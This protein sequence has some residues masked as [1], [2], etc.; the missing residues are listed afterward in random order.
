MALL[1]NEV[2]YMSPALLSGSRDNFRSTFGGYWELVSTSDDS[3]EY[4]FS[5]MDVSDTGGTDYYWSSIEESPVKVEALFKSFIMDTSQQSTASRDLFVP[6]VKVPIRIIGNAS[7]I[8]SDAHWDVI[9]RGGQYGTSSYPG[10]VK[11]A[12]FINSTFVLERPYDLRYVKQNDYEN[13][14]SYNFYS[15]TYDY[16]YYLKEYQEFY[17]KKD[18]VRKIPNF[19]D[20]LS[21]HLG[22][23]ED[24]NSVVE[25]YLSIDGTQTIEDHIF[26]PVLT[27]YLPVY[28]I[29]NLDLASSTDS[30]L[31]DLQYYDKREN[32]INYITGAATVMTYSGS[33]EEAYSELQRVVYFNPTSQDRLFTE[34]TDEAEVASIMPYMTKVSIPA[35]APNGALSTGINYYIKQSKC[36]NM[37]LNY[38]R[39]TMVDNP[40]RTAPGRMMRYK[41]ESTT[42]SSSVEGVVEDYN[43]IG[44]FEHPYFDLLGACEQMLGDPA[45]GRASMNVMAGTSIEESQ[46]IESGPQWRGQAAASLLKLVTSISQNFMKIDDPIAETNV[47]DKVSA[48][49]DKA[50]QPC[51]S[52]VLAYRIQKSI[53][54][55]I[56][57]KDETTVQNFYFW[58]DDNLARAGNFTLYDSQVKYGEPIMYTAY[59]Y[60]AVHEM[61]YGYSDI[62]TTKTLAS[63]SEDSYCLEFRNRNGG[64]AMPLVAP[65]QLISDSSDE[66]VMNTFAQ[67]QITETNKYLADFY[68]SI[69]PAIRVYE[70]P[71][72]IDKVK[73]LDHPPAQID[74][75]PYQRK[76][77]SNVIGFV[78]RSESVVASPYPEGLSPEERST[79][80]DYLFSNNLLS[81]EN[82]QK[83]SASPLR[84]VE[85]FRRSVK[86]TSLRDF[87]MRDIIAQKP[88]KVE[89]T[90]FSQ[91]SCIYEQKIPS[92]NKFY[93]LFRFVNANGTPGR[94]SPVIEA[95]LVNDGGYKYAIFNTIVAE[96]EFA[97][98]DTGAQS[99]DF[100]KIFQLVPNASHIA[101]DDTDVD[102]TQIAAI[103][104]VI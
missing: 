67:H 95:E 15:M 16:N 104:L 102:Y 70:I 56:N 1:S 98:I 27:R 34:V 39:R 52:E 46:L 9:I 19:Y 23:A 51:H 3:D 97:N 18:N 99:I 79:A 76:N 4:S 94:L 12:R 30:S 2:R 72:V 49:F 24:M 50:G 40:N 41:V 92:N 17:K 53:T 26:S 86:P 28:D 36:E 10:V 57:N 69:E 8:A 80:K 73:V 93:Y 78:L 31:S 84:T 33:T 32:F 11:P 61:N 75:T 100:K 38:I 83:S 85:V 87:T 42:M 81:E 103:R 60:V 74:V 44:D 66:S 54:D 96:S 77:N 13:Y 6:S 65:A 90:E 58:N 63:G 101:F 47:Y 22:F 37:F 29:Q 48:F 45:L 21:Y 89:D 35:S 82:T 20:M 88:I 62:L 7:N 55:V 25:Q 14:A 5:A 71:F 64:A 59:A 68:L 43:M 91:A